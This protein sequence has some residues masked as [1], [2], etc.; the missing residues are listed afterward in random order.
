MMLKVQKEIA[1]A[2][3]DSI[4]FAHRAALLLEDKQV[5]QA[6]RLCEEG[7]KRFP[8]Y[9][10]GHHVLARCYQALNRPQEARAE[11]ERTLFYMP[12]HIQ[13]QK[14]LAYLHFKNKM[15]KSGNDIL[16]TNALYDPLNREL[17]EYLKS[18]GLAELLWSDGTPPADSTTEDE[19]VSEGQET[20]EE[21]TLPQEE[22]EAVDESL[23]AESAAEE[24]SAEE[25]TAPDEDIPTEEKEAEPAADQPAT[26]ETAVL[27]EEELIEMPISS[28]ELPEAGVERQSLVD[29]LEERSTPEAAPTEKLD[30]EQFDNTEDD[31]STLMNGI[32]QTTAAS[33]GRDEADL[34][35]FREL[36]AV[37]DEEPE[38]TAEERPL[39][40]TSVIFNENRQAQEN[41]A[42]PTA[43][44]QA[45]TAETSSPSIEKALD[46]QDKE[47]QQ[48]E[49]DILASEQ[50]AQEAAAEDSKPQPVKEE[51]EQE[52]TNDAPLPAFDEENV[53]I[54][55][56]LENPRM[57]T[58]TFG[59]ILIAQKKFKDA[60]KVFRELY[61]RD[62]QN[63][64]L[65][66]KIDFLDKIIAFQK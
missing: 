36:P 47:L 34:P 22:A 4:L 64:R 35:Q 59:E 65:K 28:A 1:N 60:R 43:E 13:A 41:Q 3:S 5:E 42:Q 14:G 26:E 24:A 9:A 19:V 58:P 32:F 62:P 39:L 46:L 54:E 6:V 50:A 45:P 31:F 7:L 11:Y 40:D 15:H 20:T 38:E 17:M 61:R 25:H 2:T 66:K 10:E 8:F 16:L 52:T 48:I 51:T 33:E 57:L 53:N 56:I 37:E 63:F 29:D 55:E 44:P 27:D 18:E 21:D 12:N 23:F 49:E 30:L